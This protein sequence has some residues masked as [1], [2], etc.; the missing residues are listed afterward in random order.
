MQRERTA[1]PRFPKVF[2]LKELRACYI[3]SAE[4]LDWATQSTR[5]QES[6]LGLLELLKVFQQLHHFPDLDTI[7]ASVTEL[8]RISAS[9]NPGT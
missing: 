4:E 1:Y 3:P 7:P 9:L 5:G 8:V 2:S 6:R